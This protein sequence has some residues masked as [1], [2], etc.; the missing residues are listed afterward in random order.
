MKHLPKSLPQ[1]LARLKPWLAMGLAGIVALQLAAPAD[2]SI[3][4][5]LFGDRSRRSRRQATNSDEGGGVR[6]GRVIGA[7]AAN[8]PHVL[9]PRNTYLLDSQFVIEWSPVANAHTYRVKLW[10]WADGYGRPEWLVWQETTSETR[11]LYN[12]LLT[13]SPARYYSIEVIAVTPDSE[14]SSNQDV[15]C[16]ATGFSLL[17]PENISLLNDELARTALPEALLPAALAAASAAEQTAVPLEAAAPDSQVLE[18]EPAPAVPAEAAEASEG[19]AAAALT[20]D[21]PSEERVS[22]LDALAAADLY[23]RYGLLDL[24]IK[25]LQTP[26][27][28]PESIDLTLALADLYSFVGLTP[29]A[30]EH[31]EAVLEL[32]QQP[33]ESTAWPYGAIALEGKGV[34]EAALGQFESAQASFI[35]ARDLYDAADRPLFAAAVDRRLSSLRILQQV[36]TLEPLEKSRLNESSACQANLSF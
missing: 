15:G 33:L 32:A 13:L 36:A 16:T 17:F 2:A 30:I 19:V 23:R 11:A 9:T 31:Y 20:L 1:S 28:E 27:P 3:F 35:Q 34:L 5:F 22:A 4:N 21:S 6:T 7:I 10:R 25:A 12:G 14:I 29:L 24:A 26:A 8:V 18:A